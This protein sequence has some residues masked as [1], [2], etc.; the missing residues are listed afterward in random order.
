MEE[1]NFHQKL[2]T[3]A[4][5]KWQN[6]K[7]SIAEFYSNLTPIERAAC[8]LG[9]FNYQVENGGFSQWVFNG[10]AK[11][12]E[13]FLFKILRNMNT[14][15]SKKVT[16]LTEEALYKI[17]LNDKKSNR[18]SHYGEDEEDEYI[19]TDEECNHYYK[20]NDEFMKDCLHYLESYEE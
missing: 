10:Y 18:Y 15:L 9:H 8:V 3:Q 7:W 1:D 12:A 4:H 5:D 11:A 20:I 19:S 14:P 17:E 2:M 13:P 6:S 16:K